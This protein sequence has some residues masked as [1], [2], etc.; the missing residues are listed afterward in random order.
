[1]TMKATHLIGVAAATLLA[2]PAAAQTTATPG[3]DTP[4]TTAAPAPDPVRP[5]TQ[6]GA[7]DATAD[8]VTAAEAA[9][10][11]PTLAAPQAEGATG[12]AAGAADTS[13]DI[14]AAIERADGPT[15]GVTDTEGVDP[16]TGDVDDLGFDFEGLDADRDDAAPGRDGA[17]AQPGMGGMDMEAFAREVFDQGFR[18]GYV[19]ALTELRTQA[20]RD[21]RSRAAEQRRAQ[22]RQRPRVVVTRD[23]NGNSVIVLPPGLTARDFLSRVQRGSN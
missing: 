4:A 16:A 17:G 8:G 14:D 10:A 13:T 5:P 3:T 7:S 9:Q 23:A 12:E 20:A 1:M 21:A 15:T 22:E 19:A 18:Q 6:D 11:E 2:I